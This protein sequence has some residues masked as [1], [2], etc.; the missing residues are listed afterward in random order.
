MDIQIIKL[1]SRQLGIDFNQI[2]KTV[3]LLDEGATIPFISRYRKE[4]TGGLNEVEIEDI[5]KFNEHFTEIKN[6]KET[7]LNSLEKQNFL[8]DELKKQIENTWDENI[9]ED[10]YLPYKPKKRT[11]AAIA[12]EKGLELLAQAIENQKE[13]NINNFAKQFFNDKVQTVEEA[14][15][16]ALDIIAEH[17]SENSSARERVR[18]SFEEEAVITSKVIKSKIVEAEKYKDYFD[19]SQKLAQ[20]P[21]HRILAMRRGEIEGFLKIDISPNQENIFK[22]L[23]YLFITAKNECSNLIEKAMS[24]SYNRLIKPSI[25]TEFANKSKEIADIQS[26]KVFAEN[27]R[28]LLLAAPLGEKRILGID[29]GYRTG[30]KVVCIDEN[31]NLEHNENIYPHKP[32]EETVMAMKKISTLVSSFKIEAIAIGNG[33][34]SRETEFFIKK[35]RFDKDVQVFIV[36]EDGASVYSAS[37]IAREEFPN[38]DVTVRG[39]VSIARRLQDPLAE[40]V[41]IDP[42]SIGVGQYQHDVNQKLLKASLDRVTESAVNSVGV[43]LNTA[44]KHLLTYVSGLGPVIA[45]NIVD[46]RK[47]NGAFH[48]RKELLKVPRLGEKAFEQC[49]GFLRIPDAENPL[50]NTAVHPESYHIVEKI[51][52]NLKISVNEIISNPKLITDLKLD[53]YI[54]NNKEIGLLTLN[55]I[56]TEIKKQG[57]DPRKTVKI[58]EFDNSIHKIEDLKVGMILPGIIT[59]ITNFGAFVDIGIKP[60]GLVHLSQICEEYITS[61]TEVLKLHQYVM[62]KVSEIDIDRKRIQ[63]SMKE[64]KQK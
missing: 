49:A 64:V 51:A 36:S 15:S 21:S 40:L 53:D 14:I 5:Q 24:D 18:K 2:K 42:K 30:C 6:R 37:S 54:D 62:V 34:A 32:Q 25:E 10:I 22:K 12:K 63:L 33:T 26:I 3:E 16:G 4:R 57:R 45:Q 17:I 48:S 55:D 8:T 47:K 58:L 60:N 31:G 7:I 50:D 29:P 39:A 61:P 20:C 41:K 27:L 52:K 11:R 23:K 9:L 44:S 35:I 13:I 59:N 1:I 19:F 46:F 43:N 38:Y 28:Q 56:I